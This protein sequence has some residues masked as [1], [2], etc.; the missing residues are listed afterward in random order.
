[1]K[2]YRA[3]DIANYFLYRAEK[4]GELISNLKVQ[5]LIYYAQGIHLALYGAPLFNDPIKAWAYGPVVPSLYRKYKKYAMGG[6]PADRFFDPD[7]IDE[8]SKGFLDEIYTAFGQFSATRLI[9]F[10]HSD[11]CW[12]DANPNKIITHKAMQDSLKKYLKNGKK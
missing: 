8:K 5:K 6:V 10:T 12:K 11:Q 4:D 1:M 9:D 3:L 7:L 2:L